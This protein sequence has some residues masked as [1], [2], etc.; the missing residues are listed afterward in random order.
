M[1]LRHMVSTINGSIVRARRNGAELLAE[2]TGMR[3]PRRHSI[4]C[5]AARTAVRE[6]RGV[7]VDDG[8]MGR[9][10]RRWTTRRK[11]HCLLLV[12]TCRLN[13][14]MQ[15]AAC[16]RRTHSGCA[17]LRPVGQEIGRACAAKFRSLAVAVTHICNSAFMHACGGS[18]RL[19]SARQIIRFSFLLPTAATIGWRRTADP[20]V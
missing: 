13:A 11:R 12:R 19:S 16:S 14:C 3:R 5:P 7:V 20:S 9:R 18:F 10:R 6:D 4:Y 17:V 2:P 8:S 15:A 1:V